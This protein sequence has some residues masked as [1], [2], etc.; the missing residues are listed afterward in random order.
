MEVVR[1]DG[2]CSSPGLQLL[3]I[4]CLQQ[5]VLRVLLQGLFFPRL[6][7]CSQRIYIASL[8]QGLV[9]S[10]EGN[11]SLWLVSCLALLGGSL[12]CDSTGCLPVPA[13]ILLLFYK[14]L[15]LVF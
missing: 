5:E 1:T 6:Q 13:K 14:S 3:G 2:H 4:G 11:V 12:A 9:L 10:E 7:D 15:T 8:Q